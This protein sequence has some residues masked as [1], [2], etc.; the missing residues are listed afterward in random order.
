MNNTQRVI[1]YIS[2]DSGVGGVKIDGEKISH[3]NSANNAEHSLEIDGGVG[4]VRVN[5]MK[6]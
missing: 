4:S 3:I 1:K 2:I 5:F 6:Q